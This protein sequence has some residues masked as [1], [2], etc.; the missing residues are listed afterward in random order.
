VT[1]AWDW[2]V[3]HGLLSGPARQHRADAFVARQGRRLLS[4]PDGLAR[5][6]AEQRLGVDLHHQIA[7]RVRTQYLI[8]EYEATMF[9]AL[10]T[11]EVRVRELA[12]IPESAVGSSRLM[13]QAFAHEEGRLGPLADPSQDASES[14][15][16]GTVLRGDGPLQESG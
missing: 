2:L 1:E 8:G 13:Q 3:A 12:H 9:L 7:D 11:V 14:R 4:E 10:R 6:R 5:L 15:H 16:D